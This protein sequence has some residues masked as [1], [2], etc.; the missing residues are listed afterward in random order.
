MVYSLD[1]V[2]NSDHRFPTI[3]EKI[4][5]PVKILLSSLTIGRT[6]SLPKVL[7]RSVN[8]KVGTTVL[9]RPYL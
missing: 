8:E 2:I 5:F 4:L 1:L 7:I 9:L 6:V 3:I